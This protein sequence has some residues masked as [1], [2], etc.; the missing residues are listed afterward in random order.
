M[1]LATPGKLL[2]K[3]VQLLSKKAQPP[4]RNLTHDSEGNLLKSSEEIVIM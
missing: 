1:Q 4:P 3:Q 2:Y